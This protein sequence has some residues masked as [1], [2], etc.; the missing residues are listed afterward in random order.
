LGLNEAKHHGE[1]FVVEQ[2][3][4][5]PGARKRREEE[6]R[7]GEGRKGEERRGQRR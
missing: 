6:E 3:Y 1:K 5:L 4:S 2:S 7:K